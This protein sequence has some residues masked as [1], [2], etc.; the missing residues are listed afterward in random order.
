MKT[1]RIYPY[2]GHTKWW[3]NIIIE[4]D[5]LIATYKSFEIKDIW[6]LLI[7]SENSAHV[8][9]LEEKEKFDELLINMA[10]KERLKYK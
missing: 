9:M 8:P 5:G 1:C 4:A 10:L 2:G 6:L 3:L 7:I